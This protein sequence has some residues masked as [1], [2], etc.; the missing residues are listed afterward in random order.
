[1]TI[2]FSKSMQE[3]FYLWGDV[4]MIDSKSSIAQSTESDRYRETNYGR[5]RLHQER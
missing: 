2:F 3:Y 1:M 5:V 4:K